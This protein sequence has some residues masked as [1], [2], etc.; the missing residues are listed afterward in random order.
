MEAQPLYT[1]HGA[2]GGSDDDGDDG[3]DA[4]YD[5]DYDGWRLN[6]SRWHPLAECETAGNARAACRGVAPL[7]SV[8]LAGKHG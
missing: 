8:E 7:H 3:G 5:D 2:S 6:A 1:D 4:D